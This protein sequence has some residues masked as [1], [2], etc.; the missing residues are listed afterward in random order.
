MLVFINETKTKQGTAIIML[1]R[2]KNFIGYSN[3]NLTQRKPNKERKKLVKL[4]L[5]LLKKPLEFPVVRLI[6]NI[7]PYK[8]NRIIKIVV[9]L[10]S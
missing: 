6:N 4:L 10:G 8:N 5:K 2:V 9:I 7:M 1:K 3:P